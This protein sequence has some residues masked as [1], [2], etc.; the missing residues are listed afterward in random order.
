MAPCFLGSVVEDLLN[1]EVCESVG[2]VDGIIRIAQDRAW[3]VVLFTIFG[4]S[5]RL[6]L[7]DNDRVDSGR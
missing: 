6:T 7:A 5:L 1:A 2:G 3:D 4:G